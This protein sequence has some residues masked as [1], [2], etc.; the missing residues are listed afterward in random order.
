MSRSRSRIQSRSRS[1][2]RFRPLIVLVGFVLITACM[3]LLYP[4]ESFYA[5]ERGVAIWWDIL[6][7]A[8]FPFL[9]ISEMMLGFGIVHFLGSL[10]DPIMRPLFRIPGIGGFVAAMGFASGYPVAA[11]LTA[12]LWEE[13]LVTREEGERLVA[14]TTSSD[15]IFLIGAV[16]VG[17]FGDVALAPVLA[18]SH[19]GAALLL[20][21]IMRFHGR[22]APP[23]P[24]PAKVKTSLLRRSFRAMHRARLAD[25]RPIGVLFQQAIGSAIPLIFV[26][27][28]L[29]V[30]FSVVLELMRISGLLQIMQTGIGTLLHQIGIPAALSAAMLNGLF[31]VTLGTKAA[32]QASTTIPLVEKAAVCSFILSWAGLSVHTQIVSLLHQTNLRYFPF[33]VARLLHG[34]LAAALTFLLWP[35]IVLHP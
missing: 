33:F 16:S 34:L 13:R 20:G 30:F 2:F 1:R 28:G 24:P 3:M 32:G 5:A 14:F 8:L 18:A 6:F 7:P 12:R 9:V 23:T 19:F 21:L 31:E 11:R 15:P 4:T 29:V 17:F 25:G 35:I 26:I 22:M 10:F 27:G